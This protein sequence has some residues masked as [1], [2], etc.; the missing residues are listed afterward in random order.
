MNKSKKRWTFTNL[1][2]IWQYWSPQS[3]NYMNL[4][5]NQNNNYFHLLVN[6]YKGVMSYIFFSIIKLF[7]IWIWICIYKYRNAIIFSILKFVLQDW[8]NNKF[9]IWIDLHNTCINHCIQGLY[10]SLGGLNLYIDNFWCFV[11]NA[12][13]LSM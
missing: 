7:I 1:S 12:Y 11:Q 9:I 13:S 6:I 10:A 3:R 5:I 8:N 2:N 4:G